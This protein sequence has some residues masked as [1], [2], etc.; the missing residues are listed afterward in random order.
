MPIDKK[1]G[2]VILLDSLG[3][4]G[5]W[6]RRE[7]EDVFFNWEALIS[8]TNIDVKVCKTRG[9]ELKFHA[10]SDTLIITL[11]GTD[12]LILLEEAGI[13]T[14]S[15]ICAGITAGVYFRGCLSYGKILRNKNMLTEFDV[16]MILGNAIDEAASI[17]EQ[18]NWVGAFV[19]P[20][21][22][23]ILEETTR[24]NIWKLYVKYDVP[25]RNN[26][27]QRTWAIRLTNYIAGNLEKNHLTDWIPIRM[28]EAPDDNAIVKWENTRKF[29]EYT[30][31]S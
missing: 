15:I 1:D 29:L 9:I 22:A 28:K 14:N 10:F 12:K 26:Q 5:I 18:S 4:K 2:V 3:M 31:K 27:I 19:G 16:N 21:I 11:T 23:N 17:Y 24:E 7:L 6:K 20:S 8:S 30:T 13:T 25:L